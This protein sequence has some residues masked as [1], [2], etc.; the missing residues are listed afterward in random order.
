ME[1]LPENTV[2]LYMDIKTSEKLLQFLDKVLYQFKRLVIAWF[3]GEPLLGDH[4]INSLSSE[5][6]NYAVSIMSFLV[7]P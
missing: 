3:G 4:I 5:I 7:P 2:P 1:I 6:K